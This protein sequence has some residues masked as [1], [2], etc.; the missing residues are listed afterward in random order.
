MSE[1]KKVNKK[2]WIFADGEKKE[3]VSR[4]TKALPALRGVLK[5]SQDEVA[6]IIGVSRQTYNAVE[7]GKRKMSWSMYVSLAFFF[8]NNP[9]TH[10]LIRQFNAYPLSVDECRRSEE[11]D[12][13]D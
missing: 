3:L 10:Q 6:K 4:L 7:L 1:R 8:D 12:V 2:Y 11:A 13:L 5:V 9:A